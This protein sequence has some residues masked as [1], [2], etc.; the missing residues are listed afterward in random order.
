MG[1][2]AE[3]LNRLPKGTQLYRLQ[4]LPRRLAAQSNIDQLYRYLTDFD[5]IECKI[6][7]LEK[8]EPLLAD[9][10]LI[11]QSKASISESKV[12]TLKLIQDAIRLSANALADN[13]HQIAGQ[14]IGRLSHYTLEDASTEEP[15]SVFSLPNFLGNAIY[16]VAAIIVLPVLFLVI[17]TVVILTLTGLVFSYSS[18]L[19]GRILAWRHRLSSLTIGLWIAISSLLYS[20]IYP[21]FVGLVSFPL[22]IFANYSN[23]KKLRTRNKSQK[24]LR[25]Y[26]D[27][28]SADITM[29]LKQAENSCNRPWLGPLTSSLAM[30]GGRLVAT[31]SQPASTSI[32]SIA[33][34]PDGNR[35]VC[36]LSDK[37]LVVWDL[38]SRNIIRTL[39]GHTK[40]VNGVAII[41]GSQWAVSA[42][43]D[44]TLILWDL[45]SGEMLKE[46]VGHTDSVRAVAVTGDGQR[47][48]SASQDTTLIVWNLSGEI[49]HHLK[50]HTQ[51]VASVAIAQDNSRAISGSDDGTLI[52]WDLRT[53]H[54]LK[55]LEGHTKY[56]TSVAITPDGQRAI[57]GSGAEKELIVWDLQAGQ[58][59]RTYDEHTKCIVAVAITPDGAKFVSSSHDFTISIWN[60]SDPDSGSAFC[61]SRLRQDGYFAE[62]LAITPDSKL[63]VSGLFNT[64]SV[65]NLRSYRREEV[66]TGHNYS[67]NSVAITPNGQIAISASDDHTLRLWDL[68]SG[69]PL[70]ELPFHTKSVQAVAAMPNGTQA[71]SASM[72]ENLI[73]WDLKRSLPKKIIKGCTFS[74]RTQISIS[75]DGQLAAVVRS[76]GTLI[77]FNLRTGKELESLKSWMDYGSA[78]TF[79]PDGQKIIA[80]SG[81]GLDLIVLDI[82]SKETL[83]VLRGHFGWIHAVAVTS[84]GKTAISASDDKSIIVWDLQTGNRINVLREHAKAVRGVAISQDGQRIVSASEDATVKV[85]NL[86]SGELTA[87]FTVDS[88]LNCCAI[89]PDGLTIVAGDSSGRIHFL[90]LH[91]LNV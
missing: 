80:T 9:Y 39:T 36:A 23:P 59:L 52:V 51:R 60:F 6:S 72:D 45:Q 35:I 91:K 3:N 62:S 57:S 78:V 50:G 20:V 8:P 79:T 49:L 73:L 30:A 11:L 65:W 64:I 75:P 47:I 43:D 54:R 12:A 40:S 42:S 16:C 18:S 55:V 84:D 69:R 24:K 19:S 15:K 5:F 81:A 27:E 13:P 10:D 68:Q 63:L 26:L 58:A 2:L 29:L 67:V 14:L 38:Q 70:R 66:V 86:K 90:R 53:G 77:V 1:K 34:T 4:E 28:N 32:T 46:F 89:S 17:L 83:Q 41:P 7:K 37:T 85:W 56:V 21:L 25:N 33:I 22:S 61:E 76:N 88:A 82:R 48:V 31:L 74:S 44:Q 87:S 71:L